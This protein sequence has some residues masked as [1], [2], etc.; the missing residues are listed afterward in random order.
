MLVI[1]SDLHLTDGSTCET[2]NAGAFRQFVKTLSDQVE[3]A[4]WRVRPGT[5]EGVFE[6]LERVDVLLLGDILDVMRS[7]QW[8]TDAARPWDNLENS[9][10]NDAL[11]D[12]VAAIT[13]GILTHN[14]ASL[15]FFR[16]LRGKLPI[17]SS[18]DGAPYSIPIAF[19][20]LVGNHDWF[21]HLSGPKWDAIRARIKNAIGLANN[22][23]EVFPHLLTEN[24]TI[25]ALC[26]QHRVHVQH[27][28]IFDTVNYQPSKG[29]NASS[30]GDAIVIEILNGFP[31]RVRSELDLGAN[32]PLYRAFK[33]A[34][35]IRPLLALPDYFTMAAHHFGNRKQQKKIQQLWSEA[36][37]PFL[38]LPF[39]HSLDKPWE[40]DTVDA[41][42]ILFAAQKNIPMAVQ[43]QLARFIEKFMKPETY[44]QQAAAEESIR[45]GRSDFVV[46]GHTHRAEMVPLAVREDDNEVHQQVYINTGTWRRV[47]EQTQQNI[48]D[49]PFVHFH[50]MTYA[51]FYKGDERFGRRF[52]MWQG[53][54]G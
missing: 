40:F 19:H 35:N 29:R 20:Y 22:P 4:C 13:S 39:V 23:A 2:I 51:F 33:E 1:I 8:L 6:P 21:Y 42:Q 24:A 14:A 30:L 32:D 36:S 34:D 27:G 37:D 7:D 38:D 10:Q 50:V 52:E 54:L 11:A 12:K 18:K 9:Q 43:G 31:E 3:A 45:S 46:Y 49:F 47:H 53:S 17:I 16:N 44:S 48:T 5:S 25:A 41:L 26:E 28:D 15:D